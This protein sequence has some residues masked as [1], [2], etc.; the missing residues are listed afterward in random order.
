MIEMSVQGITLDPVTNMPIVVLKGKES[1]DI[2]PIWIGI[3]EANAIAM[4][5]EGVERPRPMTHDLIKNLINSLSASVEY[6]HIHDLKANTYYAEISLILNGE[7]IVIDSRPSD[8]INIALRCNAP[9][10]VSEAVLKQSR[11]ENEI[12]TEEE[13]I[14][15]WL[16]SIKPEDFGKNPSV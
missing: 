2:L 9:I 12:E 13:E 11:I 16:E 8:A 4:Q 7:R 5:L 10:Y 6:I 3:F 15:D 1:E 14:Q